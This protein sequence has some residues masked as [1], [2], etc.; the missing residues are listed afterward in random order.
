[1]SNLLDRR[2]ELLRELDAAQPLRPAPAALQGEIRR[3]EDAI[4]Q[5]L[6]E[7]REAAW[8]ELAALCQARSAASAYGDASPGA[9]YLDR[10]G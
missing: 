6:S 3:L 9:F 5:A 7:R 4:L 2:E 8:R 1:L 10:E